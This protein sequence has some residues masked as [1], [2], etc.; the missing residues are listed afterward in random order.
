MHKLS[1]KNKIILKIQ[2]LRKQRGYVDNITYNHTP[3]T[4]L[5]EILVYMILEKKH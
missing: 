5:K 3:L 2:Q 1:L 4:D